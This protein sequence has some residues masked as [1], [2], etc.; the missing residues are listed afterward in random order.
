MKGRIDMKRR[1]A[2]VLVL[3]LVAAASLWKLS[4]S[5]TYQ[6]FGEL[7]SQVETADSLVALTLDDGP[8]TAYTDTVLAVLRE[9]NVKATF[10]VTGREVEANLE[11]ARRIVADGH[12]L[13]NHSY[14]HPQMMLKS[15]ERIRQEVDRTDAAIRKAG[16]QGTIYFRPPYAKKLFYLPWYLSQTDRTTIMWDVEPESFQEIGKKANLIAEHVLAEV[17]PGSIILLHVMYE[18]RAPSREVLPFLIDGLRAKG[19]RLVTVSELLQ[20][21]TN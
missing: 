12:E 17:E 2:I 15:P 5:R 16:H 1:I 14:T 7:V 18:S 11:E 10:F 6:V 21:E 9:R 19:Y 20:K 4:R 8:S 3:M 13:G